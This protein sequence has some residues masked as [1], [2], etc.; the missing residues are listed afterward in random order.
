MKIG[1]VEI[2]RGERRRVDLFAARLYPHSELEI[3][4]QVIRGRRDG[5]RLV[6]C[7]ALH[8]DEINGVE[9]IRRV[10]RT[11]KLEQK[12]RGT[13]IAVPI[14][15]VFGFIEQSRY[16][17]DRRDL[18]RSFPG[19]SK[20]SLASQM[21][22]LFLEEV[23]DGSDAVIDLH[24]GSNARCNLPQIRISPD[25]AESMRLARAFDAPLILTNRAARGTLRHA[26]VSR[27]T[28]TLV[29][30]AGQALRFEEEA[31]RPGVL[32]VK[33]VMREMGMLPKLR[34]KKKPQSLVSSK[35]TWIRAPIGGVFHVESKLGA[36][37][38]K[39]EV[40]GSIS[41][42]FGVEETPVR[43][44]TKGLIIGRLER[45]LVHRGDAVIHLA[46]VV[47]PVTKPDTEKG[48]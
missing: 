33:R 25:D 38:K 15:N 30:E 32:G 39:Q 31:I 19:A 24:T 45:P 11:P 5:P 18:N 12:L 43:A 27:G 47:E 20:G 7:A 46:R 42:P 17:P 10:L 14:V 21:A 2:A 40:L 22:R 26:A 4:V 16:L 48:V 41:D 9:V 23:I 37:V 1:G 44:T 35:S 29:Y 28:P 3:P 36:I 34:K 6:V 13:L 8:G